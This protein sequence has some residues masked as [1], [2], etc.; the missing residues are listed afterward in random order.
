MRPS[1]PW[2]W[3]GSMHGAIFETQDEEM[4]PLLPFSLGYQRDFASLY[5]S[6]IANLFTIFCASLLCR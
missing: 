6:A 5:L 4:I 1:L 2:R 3:N